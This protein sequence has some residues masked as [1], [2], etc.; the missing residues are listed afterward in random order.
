[1]LQSSSTAASKPGGTTGRSSVSVYGMGRKH[2]ERF[3]ATEIVIA[4]LA[5]RGKRDDEIADELGLRAGAVAS[6]LER[7]YR[8]LGIRS[9][10]EI[11]ASREKAESR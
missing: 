2:A 1:M 11:A 3:T 6:H 9:R 7:I 4:D 5:G 8:K 10:A